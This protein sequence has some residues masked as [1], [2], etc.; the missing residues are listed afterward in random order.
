MT[1]VATTSKRPKGAV[2]F[3]EGHPEHYRKILP[4]PTERVHFHD[5]FVQDLRAQDPTRLIALQER[6]DQLARYQHTGGSENP[7]SLD[8]HAIKGRSLNGATHQCDAW[9]GESRRLQLCFGDRVAT[10]LRIAEHL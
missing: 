8:V 6:I 9:T 1:M 4:P 7:N 10:V 5:D 3:N 2:L